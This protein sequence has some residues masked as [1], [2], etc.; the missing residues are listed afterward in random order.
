MKKKQTEI[1]PIL[2]LKMVLF[3]N[4]TMMIH[5]LEEK[6][7]KLINHCIEFDLSFGVLLNKNN[8]D[9]EN[10]DSYYQVGTKARIMGINHSK[11][12]HMHVRIQ[13]ERKF[14]INNLTTSNNYMEGSIQTLEEPKIENP[15]RL[16][17][18]NLRIRELFKK[19]IETMFEQTEFNIKIFFPEDPVILSYIISNFLPVSMQTK[20][21]LLEKDNVTERLAKLVPYIEEQIELS[22]KPDIYRLSVSDLKEWI[23]PN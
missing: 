14:F 6:Y 8:R 5:V 1:I 9:T 4:T 11:E 15:L 13:G 23:L 21:E 3:P 20:Q 16:E 12:G 10:L 2:P 19:L 17:A 22:K 7:V 18:L